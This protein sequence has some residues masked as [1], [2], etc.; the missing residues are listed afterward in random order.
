M[1]TRLVD[2]QTIVVALVAIIVLLL[3]YGCSGAT[4]ST[5]STGTLVLYGGS[6]S[7]LDPANCADATAAGYMVEIFSG[8]VTL[9]SNLSVIPD[10][11]KS[12]NISSDGT[13]YTFHLREGVCFQD[14]REVNA[15]DFKYS[16]ERAADPE[17]NS[18]V[19][20]A[21]IGD[22]VG[23]TEKLVGL[24]D[25]VDGVR[26][27]DDRTLEITIDAPKAYFL[28]KLTHPVA[29]VVDRNNVEEGDDWWRDPN[30]TG[31]FKLQE[32]SS[33][34]R[35]V[36]ERND[37]YYRGVAKLEEVVFLLQSNAMT[38][39]ENGGI[40][41]VAVGVG[42]ID[43][44]L[45][46]DNALN[47][48]LVYTPELSLYYIGFN[49]NAAPFD[50]AKVRQALCYAVDKEKIVD[51]LT[52][53]TVSVAWG[54]LPEGIPGYSDDLA[55]LEF[56][57]SKAQQMLAESSYR[58]GLPPIVLSVQGSC[59]GVAAADIA[60]AYMWQENLG[61][62]VEVEAIDFTTLIQEGRG[63]ELQAF[64]M[65]WIAD[66]P[67]AENFLDLLFHCG[68]G[69]N[70]TGYCNSSVDAVLEEARVTSDVDTRLD[71]YHAAEQAIVQDA[72][73]LP[74]WFGQN[75]YLVKPY[76]K[77]FDPAPT[78]ISSLKDVWIE[79]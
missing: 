66:Y 46:P 34:L 39:Y 77:G 15:S 21:Y 26:V 13:V 69:E 42:D 71:I 47:K 37:N 52:K 45:D 33:G 12:W 62:D 25:E 57:I 48:E 58:D 18:R 51:V 67:D 41:I 3:P 49:V 68:S 6:P 4:G 5:S 16:I 17:T 72:P 24:A 44:V 40:D 55:G 50:D 76:V 60:I 23:V 19:A 79:R 1:R 61:I 10:I 43:R 32:W 70:Y 73:C 53:N 74:L 2:V 59:S 27:L 8:L 28:S 38:M 36:L 22:I 14:G 35:I 64:E 63:G 75:Y 54:I 78:I 11:A 20:E 65:G 31:P 7:T 9:D 30:G 56:N 29:Y